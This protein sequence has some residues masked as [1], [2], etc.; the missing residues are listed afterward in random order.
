VRFHIDGERW[1]GVPFFVRVGKCLPVTA[2]EVLVRFKHPSHPCLDEP[3]PP[4]ANYCRFRLSPEVAL[5]LGA[6]VK[7]PGERMEGERVELVAHHQVPDEMGP[8]E[9]LL[10]DAAAGDP[11]LFAREDAVEAAW[12]VLDPILGNA[13]P[14]YE[15]EPNTW[16]P[17][18]AAEVLTPPG[19]WHNPLPHEAPP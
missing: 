9:R 3:G 1:E 18:E 11:T 17:P 5:A 7:K 4:L 19:G 13:T 10:G 2:T 12:R 6:K 14:L 8:Y 15:Y 16:G